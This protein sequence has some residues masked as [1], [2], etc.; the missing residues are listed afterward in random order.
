MAYVRQTIASRGIALLGGLIVGDPSN[1]A[2]NVT[3]KS[4]TK[5]TFVVEPPAEE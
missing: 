5:G 3:I 1:R 4:I 2:G